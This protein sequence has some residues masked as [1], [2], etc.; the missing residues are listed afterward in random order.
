MPVDC[1]NVPTSHDYNCTNPWG[2]NCTSDQK[3]HFL[4]LWSYTQNI[5]QACANDAR[6][7][8]P[9]GGVASPQ[10]ASLTQEACAAIAGP[11]WQYYPAA[12]IWSRLT[13]WKIPLLQL[14]A[15]FPRP[16]LNLSVECFVILHLLGDPIDTLR[17]LLVKMSSCRLTAERWKKVCKSLLER[18]SGEEKDR[19][20]KALT[21]LTDAY[22]EWG[23]DEQAESALA[24][25][26][27]VLGAL[28]TK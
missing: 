15:S 25:G 13:T 20:W 9:N 12:D 23:V 16:P 5:Q 17:N 10:N 7:F 8:V 3:F 26:L 22:G 27:W 6:L 4:S 2:P 19:D 14:V 28:P 11:E 24:N 21:L 1:S 18:P